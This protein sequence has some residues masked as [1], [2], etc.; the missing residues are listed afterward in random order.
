MPV[1]N[2]RGKRR[3][4]EVSERGRKAIKGINEGEKSR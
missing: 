1:S 3:T 4:I 2:T